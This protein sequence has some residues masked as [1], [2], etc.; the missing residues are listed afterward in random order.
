VDSTNN[1]SLV[2]VEVMESPRIT[3]QPLSLVVSNGGPAT[4]AV[5]AA[6]TRLRLQWL[7]NG[8][9]IPGATNS[10][11]LI[12]GAQLEHAGSYAARVQN[13]VGMVLSDSAV[14]TVLMPPAIVAQPQSRIA[15]NGATVTF[16]VGAIGTEPLGYQWYFGG[17]PLIGNT[18]TTLT[19]ASVGLAQQGLYWAFV[20]NGLGSTAS[21]PATLTV[22][23]PPEVA[24]QPQATTVFASGTG[25]AATQCRAAPMPF[26]R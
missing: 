15:T 2:V 21:A 7:F 16:T 1:L 17:T 3:A 18:G 23:F 11:L 25:T 24:Q 9:E 14:L 4:F 12:A 26:S 19:L 13:E 10:T 22:V 20:T 6:G 5:G 8:V